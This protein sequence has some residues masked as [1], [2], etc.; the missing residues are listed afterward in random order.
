MN[1]SLNWNVAGI[2]II[3]ML[4][5]YL[6]GSIPSGLWIGLIFYKKDIRNFGSGNIGATNAF[7][8]LGKVPGISS[9]IFDVL[10]GFIPTLIAKIYFPEFIYLPLLTG[11]SAISGHLFS[12]FL[13]FQG[14][15]GVATGTGVYLAL[16]PVPTL[17]TAIIFLTAVGLTRMVSVGSIT[18]AIGLAIL[19]LIFYPHD[20]IFVAC[21]ILIAI[22]VVYKHRSNI[23][24]IMKGEENKIQ[25]SR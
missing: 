3:F 6:L 15:K 13:K 5:S 9:L 11:I 12:L 17:L 2:Y 4:I 7:R 20:Y 8:V 19:T 22:T 25:F 23:I 24:R 1:I 10:K 14:G 21:T 16:A 18:S